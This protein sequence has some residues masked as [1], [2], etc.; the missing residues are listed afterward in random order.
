M[1]K[2]YPRWVWANA[3][4]ELLGLGGTLAIGFFI[5]SRLDNENWLVVTG[6]LVFAVLAG[7]SLEGGLVGYAQARVLRSVMSDLATARWVWATVAGAGTAW[8]LGMI[9]STVAAMTSSPGT[10]PAPEPTGWIMLGMAAAI[11]I[12]LGPILSLPQALVLRHLGM[13]AW[14]WVPANAIAWSVGMALIFAGT[15]IIPQDATILL[16]SGTL[17]AT[18]LAAGCV[19]GAVHGAWL[20]RLLRRQGIGV[21]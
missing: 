5:F 8:L 9:P 11:G 6:G 15:G 2:F 19:V 12:V 18:C 10:E 14:S 7:A 20:I 17:F 3:W 13:R 4:S 16:I 1:T 21:P